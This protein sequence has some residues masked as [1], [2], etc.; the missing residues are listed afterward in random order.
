MHYTFRN[1]NKIPYFKTKLN[2][3][4]NSFFPLT[5]IEWN[6][7]DLNLRRCYSYNIAK[8]K[9]L[10]LIQPSSNSFFDCPNPI[11]IMDLVIC[12]SISSNT[13]FRSNS[14]L[15][16][17]TEMM[18]NLLFIFSSTAPCIVMNN[19]HVRGVYLI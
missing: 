7:L 18:L 8:S 15:Y 1:S 6:K 12:K 10:K 17:T 16:V 2:F 4:K 13:A 5:I 9:T 19:A 11:W 14:I 3:F